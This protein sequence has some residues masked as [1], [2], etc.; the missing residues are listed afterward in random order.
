MGTFQ[1]AMDWMEEG[2]KVRISTWENEEYYWWV[3][4]D[5]SFDNL[6]CIKDPEGDDA[7]MI[8]SWIHSNKWEKFRD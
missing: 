5:Y 2:Y 3:D 8:R 4:T 6:W 1:E 7:C